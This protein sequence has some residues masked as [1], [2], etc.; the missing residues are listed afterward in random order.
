MCE[1]LVSLRV[2]HKYVAASFAGNIKSISI[3][4]S[5][6]AFRFA[7]YH[8][9]VLDFSA[10]N[11]ENAG[12]SHILIRNVQLLPIRAYGE[13]FRVRTRGDLAQE[14][15]FRNVYKPYAVR[16][17]VRLEVAVIIIVVLL[18]NGV[19]AFVK[20]WGRFDGSSAQSYIECLAVRADMDPARP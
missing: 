8:N 12:R 3:R 5:A 15:V 2:N 19:T 4:G 9:D 13:L 18:Q 20:L 11:I 10:F 16:S 14:L 1:H 6:G 7:G 17:F